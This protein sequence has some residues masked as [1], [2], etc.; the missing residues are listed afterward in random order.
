[1]E[2]GVTLFLEEK[3]QRGAEGA[4]CNCRDG[5]DGGGGEA[6]IAGGEQGLETD[7][8]GAGIHTGSGAAGRDRSINC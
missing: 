7:I 4:E 3:L 2:T 5:V 6:D 8:G 1:M